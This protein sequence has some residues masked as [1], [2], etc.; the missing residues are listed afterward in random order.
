MG[1]LMSLVAPKV[2]KH[3]SADALFGLVRNG[4]AHIPDYRL[5]ETDIALADALSGSVAARHCLLPAGVAGGGRARA[6]GVVPG[7]AGGHGRGLGGAGPCEK[8]LYISYTRNCCSTHCRL[9]Y[10]RLLA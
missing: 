10:D 7:G 4:F 1:F 3:L 8:W 9:C 2:R 5:S 6:A